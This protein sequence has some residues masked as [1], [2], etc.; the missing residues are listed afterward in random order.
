MFPLPIFPEGG[1]ASS[2]I[3]TVWVGVFVLCFFNLRYGWVLSGLV[4]PG[5]IVPLLIVKPAAALVIVIEAILAYAIVW[6]FSERLSPGRF[7][8]LFGRDRFM[9]LI[10]SSI[11]VRLVMDGWA[12]PQF[13]GW[14]ATNYNQ[15]LDW[16]SDLRSFGLVVVSLLANQFWKPGL[17]RGLF[18]IVV[19]TGISFLIVRY[20]LM[21]LTNFRMSGV[22]YLYEGL[23]SSMLATPKAYMILVLTAMYASH[24]NVKYGWD[25]SGI[26]IPAL[27]A[28]QWYQPT[29]IVTS[30]VEAALIYAIARQVL[31]LPFLAS[32]TMEGANKILLFFNISFALKLVVGHLLVWSGWDVKTTDFYGFGYLLST[33]LAMKA[34][35]KDIFP[36]LLRST[37]QVSFVGA[38]LG[39][40]AGIALAVLVPAAASHAFERRGGGRPGGD[41][42]AGVGAG[43]LVEAIGDSSLRRQTYAAAG[44]GTEADDALQQIVAALETGTA[45]LQ[46]GSSLAGGGW[47]VTG[48][49]GNRV[50]IARADG[51]GADLIVFDARAPRDLAVVVDDAGA[52]GLALTGLDLRERLGARWL[53][54]TTPEP[55]G[56]RPVRT[57]LAAFR[58]AR[59]GFELA[60]A[61]SE[62][63]R[64][65]HLR[66]DGG[67]ATSLDLDA[68]RTALPQLSVSI[69]G[70]RGAGD[71]SARA[72]ARL[73]L[74]KRTVANLI[75][76]NPATDT[77]TASC[78]DLPSYGSGAAPASTAEKLFLR[79]Q[80]VRPLLDLHAEPADETLAAIRRPARLAGFDVRSCRVGER[81][82]IA[83]I[84]SRA[85]GRFFFDPAGRPDRLVISAARADTPGG[86]RD[87]GQGNLAAAGMELA[88]ASDAGVYAIAARELVYDDDQ[89]SAFGIVV[90]TGIDRMGDASGLVLQLRS[91]PTFEDDW[92]P[93]HAVVTLD[94]LTE[95]AMVE[96][97]VSAIVRAAGFAPAVARRS[98]ETAGF[99][100][101][102]QTALLYLNHWRNKRYAV[103][104]VPREGAN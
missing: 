64:A 86:S 78:L 73:E 11:L 10:L 36:R 35:D 19:V 71:P 91:R 16:Q 74:G 75:G 96:A 8:S 9:G 5:Y 4:V 7:P 6:V 81:T 61:Q 43:L 84:G 14:L 26:L 50:G 29:K 104:F 97:E 44:L 51:A 103:V 12:L 18:A 92:M 62:G 82:L 1:L 69:L 80:V 38:A 102:S 98:R 52:R 25:F 67:S 83:L 93:R 24:M 66:L 22:S 94:R 40:L 39:N 20:G 70:E 30:F 53:V 99:E 42:G 59:S 28:L 101:F 63:D 45:F 48:L 88:G 23:A 3:T 54:L 27:I 55:A 79:E 49:G 85:A 2:V 56:S 57:V 31:K 34:H 60:V 89:G 15:A 68:L 21:E 13:A 87:G 72:Q 32:V 58:D 41:V 17:A 77:Q 100:A 90:Q 76:G 95:D 33:L 37:L 46:D 65:A 47:R